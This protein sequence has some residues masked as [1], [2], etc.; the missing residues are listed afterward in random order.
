MLLPAYTVGAVNRVG[1]ADCNGTINVEDARHALRHTLG[2]V[3][4]ASVSPLAH[5]NGDGEVN[6][7]DV[8]LIAQA[9][10]GMRVVTGAPPLFS[11]MAPGYQTV[12]SSLYPISLTAQVSSSKPQLCMTKLFADISI[13][14]SNSEATVSNPQSEQYGGLF[15]AGIYPVNSDPATAT[16]IVVWRLDV[17]DSSGLARIF[18]VA[19]STVVDILPSMCGNGVFQPGEACDD[20]DTTPCAGSC[21]ETCSS[22]YCGDGTVNCGEDCD[23]G[24]TMGGDGCSAFCLS[25]SGCPMRLGHY[26]G[27]PTAVAVSG[28]HA[29]VGIAS[30]GFEVFDISNPV[31]PQVVAYLDIPGPVEDIAVQGNYAY[32]AGEGL[33]IVDI[34]N[35]AS[36][37][38][39][40]TT[41]PL[42]P[43]LE[44]DWWRCYATSLALAGDKAITLNTCANYYYASA[45][46]LTVFDISNPKLPTLTGQIDDAGTGLTWTGNYIYTSDWWSGWV[47]IYDMSASYFYS[48]PVGGYSLPPNCTPRKILADQDLLY[49]GCSSTGPNPFRLMTFD[50]SIPLAPVL[51]GES[52]SVGADAWDMDLAI[53][54]NHA[55]VT[56]TANG[57]LI[58]DKST[59]SLPV[60]EGQ[61]NPNGSMSGLAVDGAQVVITDE[62]RGVS[63]V[64][65]VNPSAPAEIGRA[66]A[67]AYANDVQVQNGFAFIAGSPGLSVMDVSIPAS[68]VHVAGL[69][70]TN[71]WNVKVFAGLALVPGD[72]LRIVDVANPAAPVLAG[73]YDPPGL[74]SYVQD[75]AV[76]GGLAYL[77]TGPD[78][79]GMDI[80][81]ISNPAS[82]V[83]I[84]Q[85][86]FPATSGSFIA[87]EGTTAYVLAWGE[88]LA[89][90]DVSNPATPVL[91]STYSGLSA[92]NG[93]LIARNGLVYATKYD[94]GSTSFEIVDVSNP[95]LPSML[96]Q[97]SLPGYVF[98]FN[99]ALSGD[100]AYLTGDYAKTYVLDVSNPSMPQP[101]TSIPGGGTGIDVKNGKIYVINSWGSL[102]IYGPTPELCAIPPV[103]GNNLVEYGEACDDGDPYGWNQCNSTCTGP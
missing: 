38:I 67:L 70:L 46:L 93:N 3:G 9:A 65:A 64:D 39:V 98:N 4:S 100:Y 45:S 61:F 32:L 34:S 60:M 51:L 103:C 1:D 73:V 50:I 86:D 96:G 74:D 16:I 48:P 68:P 13:I 80:L 28:G 58:F 12:E 84:G 76:A 20:G 17:Y 78:G 91:Q 35:P 88:G 2:L 56:D 99:I 40:A 29:Y 24:S 66:P 43:S 15:W 36:P 87:I 59:P 25:E 53:S 55:Y 41:G 23:D 71:A 6:V 102:D 52:A 75:V 27:A 47:S 31:Q 42:I 82:P 97:R 54:A 14:P 83:L 5:A 19:D 85:Y 44:G 7:A 10:N 33:W 79:E 8:M 18:S 30:G 57:L 81:D 92:Y 95:V 101:V 94:G 63:I 89:I 62:L 72:A 37:V 77:A 11:L 26:G 22:H 69:S 49:V 21:N 90:F